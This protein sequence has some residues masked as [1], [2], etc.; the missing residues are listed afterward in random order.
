MSTVKTLVESLKNFTPDQLAELNAEIAAVQK[1]LGE[2]MTLRRIIVGPLKRQKAKAAAVPGQPSERRVQ[3]AK[4]LA[5]E[6]AM[7]KPV[8]CNR[9][10]VATQGFS[11]VLDC[12]LFEMTPQGYKL[13]AAGR[14]VAESAAA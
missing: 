5:K 2:L 4:L 10:G 13:T 9:L 6:G 7:H 14:K 3:V 1:Q 11:Q 12:D 8:I